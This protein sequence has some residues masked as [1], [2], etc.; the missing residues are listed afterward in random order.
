MFNAVNP[1]RFR[2]VNGRRKGTVP[3]GTIVYL[4]DGLRPMRGL[5]RPVVCRN[6]WIVVAFRP[7]RSGYD[8]LART[9]YGATAVVRSLR[10]GRTEEVAE[11]V[12]L[13]HDDAGLTH[14]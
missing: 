8:G 13:A 10:D 1:C 9:T 6:P 3:V 14:N 5:T 7:S 11:W 4:Q 12:Y 2:T